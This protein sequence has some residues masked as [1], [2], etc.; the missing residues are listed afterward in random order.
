MNKRMTVLAAILLTGCAARKVEVKEP[1]RAHVHWEVDVTGEARLVPNDDGKPQVTKVGCW[2][3][4]LRRLF[5]GPK[6]PVVNQ[7]QPK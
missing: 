7:S 5:G 1:D 2:L 6:C 3:T 4:P